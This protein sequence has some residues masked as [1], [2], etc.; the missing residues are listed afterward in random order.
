MSTYAKEI[1]AVDRV[2]ETAARMGSWVS[3]L[4]ALVAITAFSIAIFTPPRSGPFCAGA[5]VV[6]PYTDTATYFP[7]DYLWMAPGI[8]LTPL[9]LALCAC[10]DFWVPIER[11][12]FTRVA[13]GLA[14]MAATLVTLDYFIQIE[15]IQPSLLQKE[16]TGLA[17]LSQ[18]NP[19][20]LFIAMED[21]GYLT[22]S[23]AFLFLAA[24]LRGRSHLEKTV[25]RLLQVG[26]GAA[27]V[28]FLG[29]SAYFRNALETRFEL[30][31]V[32]IAWMVLTAV[33]AMLWVLFRRDL[34]H[35]DHTLS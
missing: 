13:V 7:R 15:V 21:L 27:I 33:A 3:L 29:M 17:L 22:M 19:H 11:K 20:G 32:T 18:Y 26:G 34:R 24:A 5:C 16:G 6:Y 35:M 9:F 8:L 12:L 28:T 1:V 2:R 4:T 23:V 14:T 25:R 31:V 30:A 10:I